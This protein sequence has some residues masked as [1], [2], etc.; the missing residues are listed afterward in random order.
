MGAILRFRGTDA[1][2]TVT[3]KGSGS[4]TWNVIASGGN[5]ASLNGMIKLSFAGT[6]DIEDMAGNVLAVIAPTGAVE[7]TFVID[8]V[9][10]ALTAIVRQPL[11]SS[12][13]DAETARWRLTFSEDMQGID[14]TDFAIHGGTVAAAAAGSKAVYDLSVSGEDI[15]PVRGPITV[16]IKRESDIT[17]LAGNALRAPRP[18]TTIVLSS[19]AATSR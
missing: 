11:E 7:N 4:P 1:A 9:A 10:P 6:R 15:V 13:A 5:L 3:P 18:P 12:P 17:D 14:A 16:Y 2:I 19:S 8:N